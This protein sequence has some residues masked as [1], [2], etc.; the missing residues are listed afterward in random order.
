MGFH[1]VQFPTN[2]SYGT[3]GGPGFSTNIV[4]LDGGNEQVVPRWSEAR[5]RFNAA[6]G[7]KSNADLAEVKT[8]YMARQGAANGFRWKDWDDFT[9][10]PT[11]GGLVPGSENPTA[12]TSLDQVCARLTATQ[13]QLAKNYTNGGVTHTRRITKPVDASWAIAIDGVESATDTYTVNSTTGVVTFNDAVDISSQVT[14]GG[15]FDVPV[16]FDKS[17]DDWLT[18]A[19]E[20]FDNHSASNDIPV[21]EMMDPGSAVDNYFYGGARELCLTASYTLSVAEGR[22]FVIAPQVGGIIVNLPSTDDVPP[23]GPIFY[24]VNIGPEA[25]DLEGTGISLSVAAGESVEVLLSVDESL[26][27]IWYVR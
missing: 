5:H 15:H 24:I 6:W 19:F 10:N 2:I 25:F 18:M 11:N 9:T 23:G 3:H 20:G 16:R 13:Y 8:F 4:T 27:P 14:W 26:T 7:V 21:V 12:T 17:A 22:F 1:E